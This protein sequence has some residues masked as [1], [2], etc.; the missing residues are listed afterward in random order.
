MWRVVL[1]KDNDFD[2]P[3]LAPSNKIGKWEYCDD[4]YPEDKPLIVDEDKAVKIFNAWKNKEDFKKFLKWVINLIIN[5]SIKINELLN[6]NDREKEL[7][8]KDHYLLLNSNPG[9]Y[10]VGITAQVLQDG[11]VRT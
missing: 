2:A 1:G 3:T 6:L 9:Q 7:I 8:N 5:D 11:R 4:N 10:H